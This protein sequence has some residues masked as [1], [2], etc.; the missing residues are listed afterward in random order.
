MSKK[1]SFV[2]TSSIGRQS[3]SRGWYK[4]SRNSLSVLGLIIFFLIIFI[5]VFAPYITPYPEHAGAYTNFRE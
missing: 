4:F 1:E 3:L 2:V 5:A